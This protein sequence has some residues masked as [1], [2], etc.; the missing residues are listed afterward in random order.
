MTHRN[1]ITGSSVGSNLDHKLDALKSRVVEVKDQAKAKSTAVIDNVT[2]L[3]KANPLK[4]I[5]IAFAVG[6][7]GMRLLR[8]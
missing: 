8:R 5:G 3:I 6:F 1:G 7:I 4:A 2:G